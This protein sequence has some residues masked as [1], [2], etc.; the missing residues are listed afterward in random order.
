MLA[1]GRWL[2]QTP[3]LS[4]GGPGSADGNAATVA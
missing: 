3:H 1:S 4:P 2:L